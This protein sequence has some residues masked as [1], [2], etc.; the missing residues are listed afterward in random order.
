MKPR[1]YRSHYFHQNFYNDW[2]IHQDDK[3]TVEIFVRKKGRRARI[4]PTLSFT[5]FS[6]KFF[7][8]I[9][10]FIGTIKF[11]AKFLGKKK[12]DKKDKMEDKTDLSFTLYPSKS[13]CGDWTR[14]MS[15]W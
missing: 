2:T 9:E 8:T 13:F 3:I 11:F 12:K 5:S 6:P 10:P 4:K 14:S 15:G 7:I 1:T